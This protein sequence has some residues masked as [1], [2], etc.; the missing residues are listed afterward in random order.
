MN[1]EQ[2]EAEE[3]A[4]QNSLARERHCTFLEMFVEKLKG[5]LQENLMRDWA[6][7]DI[8]RVDGICLLSQM[9]LDEISKLERRL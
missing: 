5:D 9:I 7:E 6:D 1:T 8:N 3:E 2:L 4:W